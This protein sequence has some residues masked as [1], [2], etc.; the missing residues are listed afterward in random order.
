MN[1]RFQLSDTV[2]G[3]PRFRGKTKEW[4]ATVERALQIA[5][6]E[7]TRAALEWHAPFVPI[8]SAAT[9]E[10]QLMNAV[11]YSEVVWVA[12]NRLL[13]DRLLHP[14][15]VTQFLGILCE[16]DHQTLRVKQALVKVWD[17]LATNQFP[18]CWLG[19]SFARLEVSHKLAASLC[20]TDIPPDMEV[21]APWEGWSLVVPSGLLG[22]HLARIWCVGATVHAIVM[23]DG[24][25]HAMG[26]RD[27][28]DD[29][30]ANTLI[31]NLVK[32]CCLAMSDPEKFD[33]TKQKGGTKKR[34]T[35]SGPPDL[36]QARFM[37]SAPVRMDLREKLRTA[38]S[39]RRRGGVPKVQFIVRGHWK[40][41]PWGPGQRLRKTRW[42]EPYW[43][44]PPESR[45]L[46]RN[47][48]L[49]PET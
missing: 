26:G 42:Q 44:G 47:H 2:L 39:D 38:L 11:R 13:T 35:R 8:C 29:Y 15:E 45:V 41:Q 33:K 21:K 12:I 7:L 48:Q 10:L 28:R 23:K 6:P 49:D 27:E 37:L 3:G 9:R 30:S 18:N 4:V 19:S 1:N 5:G 17:G 32:G 20:L 22:E 43:K 25:V 14:D 40:Q 31:D 16:I 46:L 24:V 36:A 34:S